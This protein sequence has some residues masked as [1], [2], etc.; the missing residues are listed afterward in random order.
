MFNLFFRFKWWINSKIYWIS[1]STWIW[2]ILLQSFQQKQFQSFTIHQRSCWIIIR[3]IF[4]TKFK[5]ASYFLGYWF[6]NSRT[7]KHQISCR[8]NVFWKFST[9][10][11]TLMADINEMFGSI[12]KTT[13]HDEYIGLKSPYFE[14]LETWRL[15]Q[16]FKKLA[17]Y[18]SSSSKCPQYSKKYYKTP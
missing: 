5:T 17:F 7:P 4:S 12:K 2:Q 15:T 3:T 16:N 14:I 6:R 8:S 11:S 9:K 1:N 18:Q 13:Q 10:H